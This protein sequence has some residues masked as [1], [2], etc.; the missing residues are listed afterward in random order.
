MRRISI[1]IED[2]AAAVYLQQRRNDTWNQVKSFDID[3]A[4]D[5]ILT[6]DLKDSE[7]VIVEP[8]G[9]ADIV[10]DPVNMAAVP[11]K[12]NIDLGEADGKAEDVAMTTSEALREEARLAALNKA[13]ADAKRVVEERAKIAA[14]QREASKEAAQRPVAGPP[15]TPL[16]TPASSA[17]AAPRATNVLGAK[18]SKEVK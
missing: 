17:P 5:K 11:A 16:K 9:A 3:S 15:S 6:L 12:A 18:D 2:S 13:Q 1:S 7:R 8:V 10:Y 14:E 4:S